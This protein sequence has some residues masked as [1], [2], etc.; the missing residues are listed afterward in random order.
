MV[1]MSFEDENPFEYIKG[2]KKVT[3]FSMF[4]SKY[5]NKRTF[6]TVIDRLNAFLDY[7]GIL[8]KKDKGNTAERFNTFFEFAK[9]DNDWLRSLLSFYFNYLFKRIEAK[10]IRTG[11]A[12]NIKTIL[13][14]IIK[15]LEIK[16]AWED[17]DKKFG[18]SALYSNDIAYSLDEIN[19]LCEYP[20]DRIKPLVY[21]MATSGIRLGAWEGMKQ[22]HIRPHKNK[23]GQID[24]AYLKVYDGDPKEEYWTLITKEAYDEVIKYFEL[25]RIAGEHIN[26]ESPVIRQVW[27]LEKGIKFEP[28]DVVE[29]S[30]EGI[31]SLFRRVIKKQGLR[32]IMTDK[33]K[34]ARH[35]IKQIHGLRKTHST[36]LRMVRS[37]EISRDD[38]NLL[39]GHKGE[40][41]ADNYYRASNNPEIRIG[42]HLVKDYLRAE[43]F[44]TIDPRNKNLD[45]ME[46]AIE[47]RLESKYEQ[48]NKELRK[49]IMLMKF[50]PII[51]KLQEKALSL[52]KNGKISAQVQL[53]YYH[54]VRGRLLKAEEMELLNELVKE[55]EIKEISVITA[56]D[57]DDFGLSVNV[58]SAYELEDYQEQI[59]QLRKKDKE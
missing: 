9:Q 56:E 29:L 39:T 1:E 31:A 19:R 8:P 30:T 18:D 21:V 11:T 14:K 44:L 37:P 46:K 34:S 12:N 58:P 42:D 45:E 5:D 47:E 41:L 52:N 40:A 33:G 16:F 26:E 55:G 7:A 15:Q 50:N 43:P 17:T 23:D 38:L 48:K 57:E 10:E 4:I 54:K 59:N 51:E 25:R 36:A 32:K 2:E 28:N 49:E 35:K 13:K 20:D 27:N 53:E 3:P 24:C 22:K 6:E